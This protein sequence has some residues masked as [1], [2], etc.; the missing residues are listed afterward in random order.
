MKLE[1]F[2]A[3]QRWWPFLALEIEGPGT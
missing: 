1:K 2:Q 3:C